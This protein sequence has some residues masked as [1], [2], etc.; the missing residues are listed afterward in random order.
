MDESKLGFLKEKYKDYEKIFE[1][2]EFDKAAD[3][4]YEVLK[5][6][7]Q[8]YSE[9]GIVRAG[10]VDKDMNVGCSKAEILH[11]CLNHVM[12]YYVF[13][14]IF[15]PDADIK[16]IEM[17]MGE[18]YRTYG[19]LCLKLG[20]N[21]AAKD[22]FVNALCWNPVDLDSYLGLAE[23]F[24]QMNMIQQYLDITR[25]AYKFCCTRATMARYYRNMGFV[26]ISKYETELAR[27]CYV[28][29]NIYYHT[30]NADAELKYLENALSDK[31]P[32]YSIKD[33][34]DKLVAAG[35]EPGPDPKTIGIIYRVGE[36]MMEEGELRL[37]RDCFSIVYDITRESHL[38]AVLDQLDAALNEI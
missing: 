16:T 31:T 23:S 17:P 19:D 4:L 9:D 15:T 35:I 6:L 10:V 1:A 22:A 21:H 29:S 12:E 11:I 37:A 14:C 3:I 7:E 27:M 20:K 18:Y 38:E 25:Q 32:E 8:V 33:M 26:G 2:G 24:K 30:D 36:L 13:E 5:S 28:Y 34:Q